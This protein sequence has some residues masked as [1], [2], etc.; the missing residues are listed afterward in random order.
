MHNYNNGD[1]ITF[2]DENVPESVIKE[3]AK[4]QPIRVV[5]RESGFEN[6]HS[7][8]DVVEIFKLM[9]PDTIVKVI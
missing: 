3:I 1:L 7:K 9:A 6:S 2:I 4:K 5:F 8:I